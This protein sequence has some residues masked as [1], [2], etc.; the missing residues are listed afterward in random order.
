M[1]KD[2]LARELNERLGVNVDWTKM[3][4][5][6]LELLRRKLSDM[7]PVDS[8]DADTIIERTEDPMAIAIDIVRKK[9]SERISER[10]GG[11]IDA[12]REVG[13]GKGAL[14]RSLTRGELVPLL[15]RE[16]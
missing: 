7:I 4:K 16:K 13:I 2:E 15:K 5:N 10:I 1:R 11:I 6:D 3:R 9:G 14:L 8:I 12:A